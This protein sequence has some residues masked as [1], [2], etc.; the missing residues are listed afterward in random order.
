MLIL[1]IKKVLNDYL[2]GHFLYMSA[3]NMNGSILEEYLAEVLNLKVGFGAPALYIELLI[4]V[5]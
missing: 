5:I 4:S 3:E 2:R 1:M